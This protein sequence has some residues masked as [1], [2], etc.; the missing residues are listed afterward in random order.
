MAT[1]PI[2]KE[3]VVM[4]ASAGMLWVYYGT[5]DGKQWLAQ[6]HDELAE[7]GQVFQE[8]RR[9]TLCVTPIYDTDEVKAY[10]EDLYKHS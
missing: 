8:E 10:I 3:M 2:P 5:Q 1:K 4:K 7:F 9:Y 6:H